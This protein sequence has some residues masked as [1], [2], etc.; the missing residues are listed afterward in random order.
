LQQ[1]NVLGGVG[2]GKIGF[3]KEGAPLLPP[4][5]LPTSPPKY[6]LAP[7]G[8]PSLLLWRGGGEERGVTKGKRGSAGLG[9][10][11][12]WGASVRLGEVG[13]GSG[14]ALALGLGCPWGAKEG[15]VPPGEGNER[16]LKEIGGALVLGLGCPWRAKERRVPPGGGT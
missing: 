11:C 8:T 3:A 1:P 5:F 2:G 7:E 12:P 4:P 13:K 15:R 10:G 16:T 6:P 9:L 14:A